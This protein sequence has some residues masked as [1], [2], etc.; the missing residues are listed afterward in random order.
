MDKTRDYE[1]FELIL[2][3]KPYMKDTL[4]DNVKILS[5]RLRQQRYELLLRDDKDRKSKE[6]EMKKLS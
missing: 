5:D 3:F 6:E 4:Y 1:F 2:K